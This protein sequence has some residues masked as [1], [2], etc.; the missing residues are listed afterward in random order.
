MY[1]KKYFDKGGVQFYMSSE[2]A[3]KARNLAGEYFRSGYNC[4]ESVF[5]AFRE[6]FA[7]ELD[8][9]TVKMF[10]GLGGGFGH[11]GCVCGALSA[12]CA[13]ISYLTGRTR[14]D[15]DR[16]RAYGATK[17]FCELFE[18]RFGGTCCRVLN[19]YTYDTPEHL[20]NC[21]KITGTTAMMLAEYL[22]C[23]GLD[24]EGGA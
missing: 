23:K 6:L 13:A 10:T 20:R 9:G 11:A 21:L 1:C 14:A 19:P 4:A 22:A 24:G 17:E 7:P 15:E 2:T 5:L 16:Y 18:K 12:S 3:A 8:A